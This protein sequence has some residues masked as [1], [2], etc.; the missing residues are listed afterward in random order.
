MG[1]ISVDARPLND[2]TMSSEHRLDVILPRCFPGTSRINATLFFVRLES[3]K[4]SGKE[5][6]EKQRLAR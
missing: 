3:T 2:H 6:V 5:D 1:F 4:P